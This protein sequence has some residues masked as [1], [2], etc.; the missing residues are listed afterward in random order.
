MEELKIA[1]HDNNLKQVWTVMKKIDAKEL[2]RQDDK[3]D[4]TLHLACKLHHMDIVE[5]IVRFGGKMNIKNNENKAPFDYL[6]ESEK[7][8]FSEFQDCFHGQGKYKF[9]EKDN[10]SHNFMGQ[11]RRISM[12]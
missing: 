1:I 5:Y 7:H 6:H 11:A 8:R 9:V 4:T 2:N 10:V 12:N 3:G